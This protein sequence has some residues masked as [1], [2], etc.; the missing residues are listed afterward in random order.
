MLLVILAIP[1]SL[2]VVSIMLPAQRQ[3][4][5]RTRQEN[6]LVSRLLAHFV[7]DDLGSLS[8]SIDRVAGLPALSDAIRAQ[9]GDNVASHLRSLVHSNPRISRAFIT[10]LSGIERFDYPHDPTVIGVDFSHR[11]WYRGVSQTNQVYV[12][13]VYRRAALGQPMVVSIAAPVRSTDDT[14]TAFLVAQYS[15]DDLQARIFSL[16]L[17]EATG[18]AIIIIDQHQ[19]LAGASTGAGVQTR[20]RSITAIA[21]S[22][23]SGTHV[24]TLE[25]GEEY[26]ISSTAIP[27]P[28]WTAVAYRSLKVVQA[29]AAAQWRTIVIMFVACLAMMTLMGAVAHRAL[30]RYA[31]ALEEAGA[32]LRQTTQV[33]ERANDA[34]S[35]FLA[36]MSHEL[37]TPLNGVVGMTELLRTTPLSDRQRRFVDACHHSAD[38]LLSLINDILDLSKIEADRLELIADEFALHHCIDDSVALLAH[39]AHEQNLELNYTIDPLI[40]RRV[41]GDPV[42]LRQV[43]TNLL[44]NAVKFTESGQ[45]VL[46]AA[47]DWQDSAS[48]MVRCSVTDSGVGISA[49]R[50]GQVFEAFSQV[51]QSSTRRH[52]GTGLGLSICTRLVQAMGGEI[53]VESEEGQ[54]STFWFTVRLE[55]CAAGAVDPLRAPEDLKGLRVVIVTDNES[56]GQALVETFAS[57]DIHPDLIFPSADAYACIAD[58]DP[59]S[60]PFDLVIFDLPVVDGEGA[61]LARRLVEEKRTLP[62]PTFVL[63]PTT[64]D[65]NEFGHARVVHRCLR[66]PPSASELLDAL[67][68]TFCA[69]HPRESRAPQSVPP[70]TGAMNGLR[71]LIAEDNPTNRLFVSEVLTAAGCECELAGDGEQAV[72]AY[73]S[74]SC[75]LILMDCHMPSMDGFAATAAIRSLE[76]ES[77]GGAHVPIIA[78]TAKAVKGDREQ[79]LASGMDDYLSKPV[80]AKQLLETAARWTKSSPPYGESIDHHDGDEATP[81]IDVDAA[82]ARCMGKHYLLSL[83]LESFASEAPG[84][85]QRLQT[86]L[87]EHVAVQVREAAHALKGAAS[88]VS[89]SRAHDL[90]AKMEDLAGRDELDSCVPVLAA[91]RAELERCLALV[92]EVRARPP[93]ATED[94]REPDDARAGSR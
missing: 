8:A 47:L 42:R 3:L 75:D 70:A 50:L 53:G 21:G 60:P 62:I 5:A 49:D 72:A 37:R 43:I 79:C 46:R 58:A 14:T 29:P 82:L 54:G 48:L 33:A 39:R 32:A 45:V 74:R 51:D 68:D 26:L 69:E 25:D 80:T 34:K 87:S 9:H 93:F 4:E 16:A 44:S 56:S 30:R 36:V 81:P 6:E 23:T 57:W 85:L 92:A 65:C 2:L 12:S 24:A 77:A 18:L 73:Q 10:D 28:R 61:R 91:M 17:G 64:S 15:V 78:L 38:A 1:A 22:A 90:A 7:E 67:L 94:H 13:E 11:D 86:G 89:A 55:K 35:E 27:T 88:V 40:R 52:G 20:L 83:T 31:T 19:Q 84:Y 71:V 76:S 41:V 63:V 66:K 59:A